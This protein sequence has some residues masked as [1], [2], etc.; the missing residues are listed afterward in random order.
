MD[1]KKTL[2]TIGKLLSP[3]KKSI[4]PLILIVAFLLID[5]YCNLTLPKYTADIV[6][7]GIQN[8]D[9]N[10]II[11]VGTMMMAMVLI[12]VLATIGLSYFSSKVSAAYGRD[13]RKISYE[14]ILKFSNF[15]LNK[16]SRASLITRNTN[17]VYQIQIF[18]GLFF[19]TI[20]FS[21][22]LGIGSILKAM[23]L[24]TNLLWII[25]VTFAAAIIPFVIIFIRTVPYFKVMQELTDKINQTSREIL[26]GIP[27]IK[28]FVRQDYEEE[29]FR[30]T[31]EDFKAVNLNVFRILLVLLPAMTLLLNLMIVLILYFG[32]YDAIQGEILTGTIIAFIQYATQ[33]VMA[34]LMMGGFL[35][36]I[37]RILVSGRRVAEVINTEITISDGPINT[38]NDNPVIEFKDV[39]YSYPGSEKETLKD[40]NFKLEKGKTTAIIGGTG[41]GKSTILNLIPRLQDVTG[42]EILVNGKNIKDYKLTTLRERISYAPQKAILFEGTIRSNMLIGKED[43]SDE[44]IEKALKM[45]EVDF[46]ESLDDGVSQGASN[47]SGGQKQRLQLARSIL[48]KRDFYLFDDCFSALDMNTEAKV[49]ENLKS[50]K[51]NSSMLIV[52]Q[53]ISTIMDADEIIVLDEGEIIDKGSH[54]YLNENCKIYREIVSSQIDRSKD[55]LYDNEESSNYVLDTSYL[56][57]TAGGK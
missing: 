53:R 49:K 13:L 2:K 48:A 21:P 18:L 24:G 4:I 28:A 51:E 39:A 27:V 22:I 11:S 36:M 25:A 6:D 34:F 33:I 17:D 14:N 54:D 26:M 31:N 55:L 52:S 57:K 9:F 8:T 30:K 43:A 19:T 12:G 44:E 23:E 3:L 37:P 38:I 47:Y 50:L 32:A 16:I 45:A 56:K 15:E 20:L 29:R 40:I 5:V 41:S 35:V 46:I 7:I 42:G 10:Y 1:F